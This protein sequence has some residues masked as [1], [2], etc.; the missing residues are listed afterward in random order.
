MDNPELMMLLRP[1][2]DF[3]LRLYQ[4]EKILALV[5]QCL[6]VER[7]LIRDLAH[8]VMDG[9]EDTAELQE[10]KP[11]DLTQV[12]TDAYEFLHAMHETHTRQREQLSRHEVK[13]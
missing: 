3:E 4:V 2:D 13:P 11:I 8:E 9:D 5:E 6:V 7:Q 10:F 12:L 1:A